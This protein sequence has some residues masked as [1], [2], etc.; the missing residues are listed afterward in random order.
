MGRASF[1]A[2]LAA[3]LLASLLPA[4]DAAAQRPRQQPQQQAGPSAEARE[5]ARVSYARGQ[6]AYRAGSY[7]AAIAAFEDAYEAVP[8][9]VVLLGLAE[10]LER[11]GDIPATIETLERYLTERAD[12][13]DRAQI[14]QRLTVLRARPGVLVIAST[15]PGATITVD[16][17]D[18]GEVTPAEIE[19]SPGEHVIGATLAGHEPATE[20]VT[21]TVGGR[22]DV[23]ITLE[24]GAEP[25]LDEDPFG[26]TG[27]PADVPPLPPE[28]DEEP[29]G[30]SPGVWV[31]AG[32][33][34]AAL[35]GG[36]VLGF[37]ALSEQ[38]DFDSAPSKESA[39]RGERLALFADVAFGVAAIAGIT[40]IVLYVTGDA[41]G[42]DES[43]DVASLDVT[44][45]V[46]HDGGGL[47]AQV[48]F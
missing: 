37:L 40:A 4:G 27:E 5:R 8:N 7:D 22:H 15:P 13:P 28:V 14:E 32:V 43:P 18:R 29:E 10:A 19:V 42:D 12:A 44:P 30:L 38:S 35:V 26:E 41:G 31:A 39:D 45:V 11:K 36:T 6:E 23:E 25:G 17:E 24:P 46:S 9:P 16:G 47:S 33:A 1:A 34:G 20:T 2:V 48:R 3:V 21:A